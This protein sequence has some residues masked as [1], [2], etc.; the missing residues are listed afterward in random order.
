MVIGEFPLP[1]KCSLEATWLN[2]HMVADSPIDYD[3][4]LHNRMY[5]YLIPV[6]DPDTNVALDTLWDTRVPKDI[7]W[8]E[9]ALDLDEEAAKTTPVDAL[10]IPSLW[11]VLGIDKG[12]REIFKYS[13]TLSLASM[14]ITPYLDTTL[15]YLPTDFH[16][17]NIS[18][19]KHTSE[20]C[21]VLFGASTAGYG[22]STTTLPTMPSEQ[23]W[24][25]L[26]YVDILVEQA[27]LAMSGIADAEGSGA[28]LPF[29]SGMAFLESILEDDMRYDATTFIMT[30]TTQQ[31]L[32]E[33]TF[34]IEVPGDF[35]AGALSG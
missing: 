16:P 7:D 4:V 22:D 3:D 32:L 34:C 5:G 27:W 14:G 2:H 18:K 13:K 10:G 19:A 25:R 1:A 33:G 12:V 29:E 9:D 20:H 23:N 15:K 31:H 21:M 26:Q 24:K 6:D 30:A 28:T 11:G 17:V 35:S 8:A